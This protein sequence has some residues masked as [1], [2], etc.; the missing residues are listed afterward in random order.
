MNFTFKHIG[1]A[2]VFTTALLVLMISPVFL[3]DT[4]KAEI[5]PMGTAEVSWQDASANCG[6]LGTDW[7]LPTLYQLLA[8]YYRRSDIMLV[9][10]TDYWSRNQFMGYAFGLNTGRGIA[11]FDRFADTDHYLCIK[12]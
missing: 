5:K 10:S 1:V 6:A 2:V 7:T 3:I 4:N 9:E 11:S 12:Q 8:I